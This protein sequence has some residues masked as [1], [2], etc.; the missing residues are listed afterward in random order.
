MIRARLIVVAVTGCLLGPPAAAADVW[1][2][3]EDA[4]P[5]SV[6]IPHVA[7]RANGEAVAIWHSADAGLVV[8]VRRSSGAWTRARSLVRIG[9]LDLRR[10]QVA[11][12]GDGTA[13]AVWTQAGRPPA[14]FLVRA[15]VRLPG[16]P[17]GRPVTIGRAARSERPEPRL[18]VRAG[19][20]AI[21]W[22]SG[23]GTKL[24]W[25]TR[26]GGFTAP[27]R[28]PWGSEVDAALDRTGRL[29]VLFARPTS[30]RSCAKNAVWTVTGRYGGRFSERR[31]VADESAKDVAIEV[32]R[33]GEAIAVWRGF[34]CDLDEAEPPG[35]TPVRAAIARDGGRFR[36]PRTLTPDGEAALSTRLVVGPRGDALVTWEWP[37][38][39]ARPEP[40]ARVVAWVAVRPAGGRFGAAQPLS[41]P[42][43]SATTPA[44]AVDR[45][46]IATAAVVV[47]AAVEELHV[48]RGPTATPLPPATPLTRSTDPPASVEPSYAAALAAAGDRTVL[49]W[50]RGPDHRLDAYAAASR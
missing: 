27:R 19:M 44:I 10:E 48:T 46:G 50:S 40:A 1:T 9:D 42:G 12:A 25:R 28:M 49:L 34:S 20:A 17:F 7:V 36:A 33:D 11:I 13:I 29:H 22:G 43:M 21:V 24:V 15:S 26:R 5:P 4:G 30:S 31:L 16:G 35:A 37:W 47:R 41:P 39:W 3:P 8:A 32:A 38:Y 45:Q 18:T 23:D 14:P 2:G 6:S